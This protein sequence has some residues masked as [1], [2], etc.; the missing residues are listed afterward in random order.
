[1]RKI[2]KE[3]VKNLSKD[4]L[5]RLLRID[6]DFVNSPRHKYSL[7]SLEAA[8]PNGVTDRFAATLLSMSLPEFQVVFEG[9]IK[10]Y[11]LFF[12]VEIDSEDEQI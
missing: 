9:A 3:D 1:M 8:N 4:Q 7:A 12:R 10:K 6:D 11:R 2:S 5:D